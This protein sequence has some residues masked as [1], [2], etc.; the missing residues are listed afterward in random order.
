[1]AARLFTWLS[2]CLMQ[3]WVLHEL[4]PD[5]GNA[6]LIHVV[7]RHPGRAEFSG[8]KKRLTRGAGA[9]RSS[10]RSSSWAFHYIFGC[11]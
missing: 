6:W 10:F 4:H 3:T 7:G 5:H 1:M 2:T 9:Y 11:A 8:V